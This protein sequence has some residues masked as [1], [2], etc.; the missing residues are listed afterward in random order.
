MNPN[1]ILFSFTYGDLI[2]LLS[3]VPIVWTVLICLFINNNL[4]RDKNGWTSLTLVGWIVIFS[5][6]PVF[7]Y[8][9]AYLPFFREYGAISTCIVIAFIFGYYTYN[10]VFAFMPSLLKI[11]KPVVCTIY[12]RSSNKCKKFEKMYEDFKNYGYSLRYCLKKLSIFWS[13]DGYENNG[14]KLREWRKQH[15]MVN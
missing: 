3:L 4:Y 11:M 1:T 8:S 10:Y 6:F 7:I 5:A 9:Y 14:Y 12:G 2:S 13:W 15:G